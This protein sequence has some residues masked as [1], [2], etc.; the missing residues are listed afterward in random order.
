MKVWV[1]TDTHS[2]GKYLVVRRDGTIPKWPHFVL[3]ASDPAAPAALM[4]Y[5]AQ[6]ERLKM[7]ADYV[8]S[9]RELAVEYA[10]YRDTQKQ[11]DPGAPPHRT[12]DPYVLRAMRHMQSV[13]T[14]TPDL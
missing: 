2:E 14:V 9:I 5:A 11:G 10:E 3:A 6:A 4:A 1:K 8:E 12:D 7:P 13:I